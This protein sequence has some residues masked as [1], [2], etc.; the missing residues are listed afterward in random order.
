MI[1]T[2]FKVVLGLGL[3]I[4]SYLLGIVISRLLSGL[5][6][7]SIVGMLVLFLLL[8]LKIFKREWIEDMATLFT[9]NLILFFIPFIVG[10]VLIPISLL[11][12]DLLAIIVTFVTSTFLILWI[13]GYLVN[14]FDKKGRSDV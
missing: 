9:D 6:A 10:I 3:L 12:N 7:P 13:V 5:I 11:I 4:L 2:L 14:R 1:K 8:E